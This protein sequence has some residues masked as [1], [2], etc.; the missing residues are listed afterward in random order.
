MENGEQKIFV[1]CDFSDEMDNAI[2]HGMK[3]AAILKKELCLFHVWARKLHEKIE[4]A[5]AKLRG[6]ASH[7]VQMAP[8]VRVRYI[9][10]QESFSDVLTDLAEE[11]DCIL[12]VAHKNAVPLLLPDLKFSGFPFLF[13]SSKEFIDKIYT[14]IIV[15]VGYMKKSKDLALWASYLGRHNGAMVS[16]FTASE[17]SEGDKKIVKR[18]LFSIERLYSKFN[19]PFQVVESHSPTWKLQKVALIHSLSLKCSLLIIAASYK[20][21]FIDKL[22][23]LTEQKVIEKSEDLSVMCVNSQRDFY[24]F[25]G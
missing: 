24:T 12:L 25:C 9:V 11:Y 10:R 22:L 20:L 19:F 3:I 2:E 15:P 1:W 18:N 6:I 8:G 4:M 23:G 14:Q 21:T 13:V 5:E 17:S 16:I 7:V